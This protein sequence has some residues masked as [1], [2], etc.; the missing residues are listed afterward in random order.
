MASTASVLLTIAG[1]D[2]STGAGV[3][4]D[5]QVFAAHGF[6]GTAAITA[7][8]V[9][10]TRGVAAVQP[11]D[12]V[13]LS[14]TLT[15]LQA[16][17]PAAGIKIGMLGSAGVV[18][19]VASFLHGLARRR[20]VVLDPVLRSSSGSTLL[21][22]AAMD[23]LASA[24]L[25]LVD[26]IT[27]NWGELAGLS[28]SG[29]RDEAEAAEAMERLAGRYP[30]L[31]IVATGG[32]QEEPVDILRSPAGPNARIV[33]TDVETAS[34]HGTGCAFS[35]AMLCGLLHG[36]APWDAATAAKRYVE[37]GLRHAPGLG[38]GRGPMNLLW[39]LREQS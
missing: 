18:E 7:L 33:G 19:A 39:P 2:P 28:G 6:F 26:W 37:G 8:T 22:A 1:F 11:V 12:A 3:T 25:P 20:T 38:G 29:V 5:L 35:S 27:P 15:E 16:D 34:T 32:D 31:G 17:L 23:V 14:A 10:S 21:E 4:A 30:G 9:Q 24:L 13:L 36:L